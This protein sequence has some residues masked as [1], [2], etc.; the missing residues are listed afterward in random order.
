MKLLLL[1]IA[2]AALALT[3]CNTAAGLG[4]DIQ[5]AGEGISRGVEK[6][7]SSNR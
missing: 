6:V 1:P 2:F 5:Q 3:S 7:K 4:R